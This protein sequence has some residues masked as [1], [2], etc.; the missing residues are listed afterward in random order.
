MNKFSLLRANGIARSGIF[1]SILNYE[2]Q[3]W[4]KLLSKIREHMALVAFNVA[5]IAVN[6]RCIHVC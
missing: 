4:S 3:S 2:I 5:S 6:N 1:L